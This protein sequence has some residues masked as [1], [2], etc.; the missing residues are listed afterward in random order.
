MISTDISIWIQAIL[1]LVLFTYVLGE[2]PLFN[3]AENIF[4]G[5][6]TALVLVT[7]INV[8]YTSVIT[9]IMLQNS[10][11]DVSIAIIGL[12][13]SILVLTRYVRKVAWLGNYSISLLT[14]VGAGLAVATSLKTYVWSYIIAYTSPLLTTSD[15]IQ[16]I[17][18]LIFV[19]LLIVSAYYF[20]MTREPTTSVERGLVKIARYSLLMWFAF[21]FGYYGIGRRVEAF[22]ER[23]RFILWDWL[24]LGG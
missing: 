12:L 15:P 19:V 3:I 11:T 16:F 9:P 8:V 20:I 1:S 5:S 10:V 24:G 7:A 4:V 23:W 22:T 14:G 18:L 6:M 17:N 2:N 13:L 21:Q